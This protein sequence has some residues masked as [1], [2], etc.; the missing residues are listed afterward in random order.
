MPVTKETG[1]TSKNDKQDAKS[2]SDSNSNRTNA[3][4]A[5]SDSTQGS[6]V[7]SGNPISNN[8]STG[9]LPQTGN[10]NPAALIAGALVAA[11]SLLAL[12]YDHKHKD[13][14]G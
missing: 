9:R 14:E 8:H 3:A 5:K 10:E 12:G 2:K 6:R 7:A 4:P 13:D 1:K 11:M